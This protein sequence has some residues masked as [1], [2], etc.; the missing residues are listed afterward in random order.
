MQKSHAF[1]LRNSWQSYKL[2]DWELF[3]ISETVYTQL[4]VIRVCMLV[5]MCL[6]WSYCSVFAKSK[7]AHYCFYNESHEGLLIRVLSAIL[8]TKLMIY[9]SVLQLCHKFVH[10]ECF[11]IGST[12]HCLN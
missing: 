10:R 5:I 7:V 4:A 8:I 9:I 3:H 6:N 12:D 2:Y 1:D 11:V